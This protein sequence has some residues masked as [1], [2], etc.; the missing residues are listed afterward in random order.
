MRQDKMIRYSDGEA[1]DVLMERVEKGVDKRRRTA[2]ERGIYCSRRRGFHVVFI[3]GTE[4]MF[5][6]K[7]VR[8]ARHLV[9]I[10]TMPKT[11]RRKDPPRS[12][13]SCS[14]GAGDA[15]LTTPAL[16]HRAADKHFAAGMVAS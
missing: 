6:D 14:C 11:G 1:V 8:I 15:T 9:S 2:W 4:L 10:E 7:G 3:D 16:A 5:T 12:R 13:W